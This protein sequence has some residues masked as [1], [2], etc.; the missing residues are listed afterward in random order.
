MHTSA[1]KDALKAYFNGF[2]PFPGKRRHVGQRIVQPEFLI[3]KYPHRMI[4]Q[5][6]YFAHNLVMSY[7]LDQFI[8]Q[9]VVVRQTGYHH[10]TNPNL[11]PPPFQLVKQRPGIPSV[12]SADFPAKFRAKRLNV[13]KHQ[14]RIIQHSTYALIE[15]GS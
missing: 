6:F 8:Q 7:K 11:R 1:R 5:P 14:I 12:T 13:E 4:R 3:L 10:M 15:H 2:Y 9:R